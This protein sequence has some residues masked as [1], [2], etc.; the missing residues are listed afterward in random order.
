[1]GGFFA[2]T[3]EQRLRHARPGE[4]AAASGPHARAY[5]PDAT[6]DSTAVRAAWATSMS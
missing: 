1:V 4:S 3:G 5:L 6:A 2:Q